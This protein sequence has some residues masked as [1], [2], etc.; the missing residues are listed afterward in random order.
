[1]P[2]ASIKRCLI[3]QFSQKMV[4]VAKHIG[5]VSQRNA[6]RVFVRQSV[7][8]IQIP[9]TEMLGRVAQRIVSVKKIT[10][11]L[12]YAPDQTFGQ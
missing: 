7:T 6:F 5:N 4:N 10:V 1:M 9:R 2:L 8:S 11:M 12:V 3:D